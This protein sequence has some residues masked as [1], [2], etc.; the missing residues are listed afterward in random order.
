MATLNDVAKHAGVSISTASY[1]VNRTKLHKVGTETRARILSAVQ[2]L[3]YRPSIAGRA[4]ARGKTFIIGAV[5]PAVSQSF[6]PDILQGLEDVLNKDSYSLM[7]CIYSSEQEME[8]KCRLLLDKKVDGMVISPPAY[9]V[10]PESIV[11]VNKKIPVV[12]VT[13]QSG[14]DE[15]PCVYVD[16]ARI[17]CLA[18]NHLLENG[19]RRIGMQCAEDK[20]RLRGAEAALA[21]KSGIELMAFDKADTT[22]PEILAWG[23]SQSRPPT[24]YVTYSDTLASDLMAAAWDRGM[25]V[26]DEIS[27]VGVDG[28]EYGKRL[29]PRLTTVAQPRYEQGYEAG[30][31]LLQRINGQKAGNVV[32]QPNLIKRESVK[33]L[34]SPETVIT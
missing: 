30:K 11:R 28:E 17:G 9:T 13:K 14:S 24:A 29:R 5:F 16:G 10:P 4:L 26:P 18:V 31:V 25:E 3:N 22:G 33:Q 21:G 15:I 7:L 20:S 32:L 12:Y 8:E 34:C 23:L 27:V 2:E 6:I 19:H 1:V